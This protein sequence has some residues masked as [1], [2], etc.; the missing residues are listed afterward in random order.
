MH[1]IL[2]RQQYARFA[3]T[4]LEEVRM[5]LEGCSA[6]PVSALSTHAL[7]SGS[8]VMLILEKPSVAMNKNKRPL[9][10][11]NLKMVKYIT[12]MISI[13]KVLRCGT[14]CDSNNR[15]RERAISQQ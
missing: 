11:R 4:A 2:L 7:H 14:V 3:I 12:N 1:H 15:N 9:N 8:H 6:A 13:R 10:N 5:I